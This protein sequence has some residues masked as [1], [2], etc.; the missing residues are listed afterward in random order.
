MTQRFSFYEDLTRRENLEFVARLYGVPRPPAAGRARRWSASASPIARDQ[1]A[2]AAVGRLEAAPGARRLRAAS[3][4]ACC[5]STNR[6]PASIPRR[7]ASSGTDPRAGRRRHDRAGQPP[8]TWTRRSAATQVVYLAGGRLLV[9]GTRRRGG[10]ASRLWSPSRSRGAGSEQALA[11]TC[12]AGPGV[13]MPRLFGASL[14]VAASTAPRCERR[15][16]ALPRRS[17][18]AL[19]RRSSRSSTTCSSTRWRAPE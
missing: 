7:G 16:D 9:Q 18:A 19:G 2:Q 8:T 15:I 6:P 5:C 14:H 13:E 12:A 3:R 10:R 1:L 4:R 17:E 11:P